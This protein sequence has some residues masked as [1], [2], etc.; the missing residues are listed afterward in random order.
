MLECMRAAG[1]DHARCRYTAFENL[2]ANIHDPYRVIP[3]VLAEGPEPYV[4]FVHQDVLTD[5]GASFNNLISALD[6]LTLG[7]P[8][9]AIVG[10]GGA[11]RWNNLITCLDDP[12]GSYR[13]PGLPREVISL[14]ENFL[15]FRRS[16]PLEMSTDLSGFHFYGTDACLHAH[17]KG[18]RAY[19]IEFPVTH[20][21]RGDAKS[22]AFLCGRAA[23]AA[24]WRRRLLV[25]LLYTTCTELRIS[26]F[27]W[28]ED[29]LKQE[30]IA[31]WLRKLKRPIISLPIGHQRPSPQNG[32]RHSSRRPLAYGEER[33]SRPSYHRTRA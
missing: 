20:L 6:S 5:R 32:S 25:G 19:V 24:A 31:W 29:L 21:S 11:D 18:W 22:D 16:R 4:L 2:T 13:T 30:W 8:D 10:T 14:D 26:H 33:I 3:E 28:I 17:R 23:F 27:P 12:S 1:F 9:W 7:D 15:L